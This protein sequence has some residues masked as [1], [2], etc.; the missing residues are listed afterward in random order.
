MNANRD[1]VESWRFEN[2]NKLRFNYN[3]NE[4]VL[5]NICGV[6]LR[7]WKQNY[8]DTMSADELEALKNI[9]AND[10]R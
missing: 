5:R 6:R 4:Y 1:V 7:T 3:D 10:N 9:C 8:I 2:G